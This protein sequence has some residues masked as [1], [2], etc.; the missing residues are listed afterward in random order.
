[1]YGGRTVHGQRMISGVV[2]YDASTNKW[3]EFENIANDELVHNRT[4][5]CALPTS[6][7]CVFVG[8]L[9]K[10]GSHSSTAVCLNLF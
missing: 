7:G 3:E 6:Q 1:M 5:H 4:G 8:G 10:G 2:M 9:E